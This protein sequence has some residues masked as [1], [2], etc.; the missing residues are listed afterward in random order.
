MMIAESVIKFLIKLGQPL[1]EI[2]KFLTL[3]IKKIILWIKTFQIKSL[4]INL[5][6]KSI[7]LRQP[8]I[9]FKPKLKTKERQRKETKP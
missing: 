7:R 1:V 9:K 5:K 3:G 8:K 4:R 6:T 2:V